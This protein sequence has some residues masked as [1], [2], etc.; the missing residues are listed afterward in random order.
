MKAVE[1]EIDAGRDREG[2]PETFGTL[3]LRTGD[4]VALVGPTGSGKSRLLADIEWLSQ[5]DSPTGRHVRIHHADGTEPSDNPLHRVAQ[6]SQSMQFTLDLD[7]GSFLQLHAR[8]REVPDPHE[9]VARVV[10]SACTLCGESFSV[11]THLSA[12]SGGQSR[13]LMISDTAILARAPV[14]L[15]DEVENAGVDRRRAMD[16]LVSEDKIVLLATHDPLLALLAPWRLVFS[17]GG[18]RSVRERTESEEELLHEFELLDQRQGE[19]RERLR[20]GHSA[21][22]GED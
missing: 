6:L 5:G 1:L 8:A 4:L 10:E 11:A 3:H 12:L 18:I 20:G 19:V 7:V 2:N 21:V 14:V 22:A 16:L 13:A 9:A 17:H 15:V